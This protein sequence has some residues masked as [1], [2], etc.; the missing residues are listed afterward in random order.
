MSKQA[1]T[2][3]RILHSTA[4]LH[5]RRHQM[6]WGLQKPA[7]LLTHEPNNQQSI[8]AQE[9][10]SQAATTEWD[11]TKPKSRRTK[12]K[13]ARRGEG[14]K[15]ERSKGDSISA[16]ISQAP[17]AAF[18]TP[19]CAGGIEVPS[20]GFTASTLSRGSAT[21]QDIGCVQ[22]RRGERLSNHPQPKAAYPNKGR[23]IPFC[24]L[25]KSWLINQTSGSCTSLSFEGKALYSSC[26]LWSL[27]QLHN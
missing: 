4:R 19:G 25:I 6:G 9:L 12:M 24:L 1:G 22:G 11:P 13:E 5:P 21:H 17:P 10:S 3:P 23:H 27:L 2:D 7:Q 26:K 20:Q 16:F 8:K 14:L 18:T 15:L